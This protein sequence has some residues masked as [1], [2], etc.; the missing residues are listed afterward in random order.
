MKSTNAWKQM[1][2]A[3]LKFEF[4][5]GHCNGTMNLKIFDGSVKIADYDSFDSTD[6]TFT[7]SCQWPTTIKI[8]IGNKNMSCD[9]QID[10]E[11][12]IVAD[13]HIKLKKIVVDRVEVP[14]EFMKSI[15]L[16]TNDNQ[17]IQAVYWGFPGQ[18]NICLDQTDS[19]AWHLKQKISNQKF[20]VLEQKRI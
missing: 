3:Q 18:V 1:S 11:G 15:T 12:K 9:T 10:K 19:F 4:G 13:K 17:K 6:H 2:Q 14:I 8:V 20:T 16:E 7:C 5:I